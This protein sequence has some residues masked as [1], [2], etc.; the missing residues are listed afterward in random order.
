MRI[1]RWAVALALA[2]AAV[3][4][5]G[6]AATAAHTHMPAMQPAN[7]SVICNQEYAIKLWVEDN[8]GVQTEGVGH[9]LQWLPNFEYIKFVCTG[10]HVMLAT[11]GHN[12]CLKATRPGE[13][14]TEP[15]R[16]YAGDKLEMWRLFAQ[17]IPG[18]NATKFFL[19]SDALDPEYLG[20]WGPFPLRGIHLVHERDIQHNFAV[21]L[22]LQP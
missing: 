19:R 12:Q 10:D 5:T 17:N 1:K 22:E 15:R 21:G 14:V 6:G 11:S 4:G 7:L 8:V 2:T 16:C 9:D 18:Q 3:L 13:L 20:C